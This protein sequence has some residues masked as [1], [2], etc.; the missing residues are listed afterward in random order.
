M[1]GY[2]QRF[3]E[4]LKEKYGGSLVKVEEIRKIEPNAKEYLNKLA[5]EGLIERVRWGWYW[6][7]DEI[8]D[9][10]E[11]FE[12]DRNF[13]VISCQTAAS[14]WNLDFV[15][16]EVFA[17][18]VTNKSYGKALEE[19]FKRRGWKI[20]VEVVS[21]PISYVRMN[22][23]FVESLDETIIGCVQRWAFMDAFATLYVNRDK[24]NLKML[25]KK[26][27]WRRIKGTDVRVKQAIEYGCHLINKLT[28]KNMFNVR[29]M[30]IKDE[31][32]KG[33]IEEAVEKVVE[34]A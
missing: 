22:G 21:K 19:F 30:E 32:L 11:F 12:K 10:W 18:K 24:I 6:I 1:E 8:K 26:C 31:Y 16:R 5:R 25:L 15:H 23:L 20:L 2:L 17:V 3:Y 14:L 13:K 28:G 9:P 34:L 4:K 7:P 29:K 33:W 27:Y